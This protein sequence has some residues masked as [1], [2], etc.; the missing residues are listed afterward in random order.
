MID[1]HCHILPGTDDGPGTLQDAIKMAK[2]A[3]KDGIQTI[4]ATPHCFDG[5]YEAQ[6]K[7][8]PERCREFNAELEKN[9]VDVQIVPGGEVRLGPDLVD[10]Y[11][12]GQIPTLGEKG[13]ALLLELPEMFLVDG[14]SNLIKLL[15]NQ[16]VRCI[17][18]HP[19]R[20][21]M[22]LGKKEIVQELVF[23]GA[24]LQIT[25]DSLLGKFGK[26]IKNMSEFILLGNGR[27]YVASD[28]HCSRKRKPQ[29]KKAVKRAGKLIGEDAALDL[30][31][32]SQ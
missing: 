22:I 24:E 8:I 4:V 11:N 2:I 21:H 23:S 19:E 29:L 15:C 26:E 7:G 12:T 17:L 27:C 16:G 5:Q 32:F 10:R 9:N 31:R 28:A 20:N 25:G 1:I 18:A 14:V 13:A 30:V 6:L 3:A